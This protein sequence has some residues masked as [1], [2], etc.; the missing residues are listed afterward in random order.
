MTIYNYTISTDFSNG[1][2]PTCL[3]TTIRDYGFSNQFNGIIIEYE[4]DDV[5]IDFTGSLSPSD[6]ND[7]D[8]IISNHDPDDCEEESD[9]GKVI[10]A[11]GDASSSVQSSTTSTSPQRKL[12]MIITDLPAGRYR[13]GWY[14]EYAHSSKS[15]DFRSRVQLNDSID[16]MEQSQEIKEAGTDQS[17]PVNGFSYQNLSAGNHTID[18]DYW[19]EKYTVYIKN[20]KLE[21][22]RVV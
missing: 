14:F 13:I 9:V 15:Y 21:I 12:R 3:N 22:W 16:L 11:A 4:I 19:T 2:D 18:L 6:K 10:G 8:T 5:I 17:V 1:I 20:A 7:L